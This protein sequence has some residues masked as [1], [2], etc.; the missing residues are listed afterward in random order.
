[1]GRGLPCPSLMGLLLLGEVLVNATVE[2]K[3]KIYNRNFTDELG[4]KSSEAFKIFEQ[5]FKEQVRVQRRLGVS[6]W[7]G[8]TLG[9]GLW[10]VTGL[11]PRSPTA[12]LCLPDEA[13]LQARRGLPRRGDPRADVSAHRGPGGVSSWATHPP[14]SAP[15]G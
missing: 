13:N 5:E 2:M 3:T 4:D 10:G 15:A 11:V 8:T 7:W 6:P 14:P 1:M 9:R 12:S